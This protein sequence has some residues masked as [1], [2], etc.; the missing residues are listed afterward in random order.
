MSQATPSIEI[1]VLSC[2][3]R[4]SHEDAVNYVTDLIK[5]MQRETLVEMDAEAK[6]DAG[7]IE[8]TEEAMAVGYDQSDS[9]LWND[10]LGFKIWEMLV[11]FGAL[12]AGVFIMNVLW[13]HCTPED[14]VTQE[15]APQNNTVVGERLSQGLMV[16]PGQNGPEIYAPVNLPVR[17]H[18]LSQQYAANGYGAT[19]PRHI[20]PPPLTAV[21]SAPGFHDLEEPPPYSEISR[22]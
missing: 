16:V 2:L 3:P 7:R 22:E 5:D 18:I 10:I 13:V 1:Y 19:L 4:G 11:A 8:P 15:A 17:A 21:P 20:T 12:V 6:V 14:D 9:F